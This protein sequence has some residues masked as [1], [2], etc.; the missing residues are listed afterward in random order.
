MS[1]RGDR[2]RRARARVDARAR[3]RAADINRSAA[4]KRYSTTPIKSRSFNNRN[5]NKQGGQ[6]WDRKVKNYLKDK[7]SAGIG[8]FTTGL[9]AADELMFTPMR[10]AAQNK[11]LMGDLYND[12]YAM[13]EIRESLMTPQDDAFYK[14][15]KRLADL[16][17]DNQERERLMDIANTAKQN[18]QISSRLNYGLG[19]LGFDTIGKEP[20]E[21]YTKPMFGESTSRFNQENFMSGIES[22]PTGK[23]FMAEAMKAANKAKGSN[24][25][26]SNKMSTYASP[27]NTFDFLTKTNDGTE[28]MSVTETELPSSLS[29]IRYTEPDLIEEDIQYGEPGNNPL[30]FLLTSMYPGYGEYSGYEDAQNFGLE[31]MTEKELMQFASERP[32]IAKL[33][34]FDPS[35]FTESYYGFE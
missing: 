15:Y 9:K 26:I 34:G 33:F 35:G 1:L 27:E 28:D 14:K 3:D 22:T 2:I 24:D 17:S 8:A 20:F 19:T 7:A 23:A 18:A 30:S 5:Y 25:L 21:S 16:A 10:K 11:K 31:N 32:Q 13:N 29:A 6:S 12:K 4:I